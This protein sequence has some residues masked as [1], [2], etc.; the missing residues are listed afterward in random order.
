MSFHIRL[1]YIIYHTVSIFNSIIVGTMPL[2][3]KGIVKKISQRYI[4]GENISDAIRV[5][6]QFEKMNVYATIDVLGEFKTKKEQV[7]IEKQ[8]TLDLIHSI[9]ENKLQSYL[10]IKLTSIGMDIDEEYCFENL[11][12]IVTTAQKTGIFVRLDME[13]S[14]YTTKTINMYKKIREQGFSNIGIVIQAYLKRSENDIQSLLEYKPS[15]RLCKGIYVESSDIALKDPEQIR[16]NYKKLYHLLIENGAY[17]CIAT[18]DVELLN[19][20]LQDIQ[21]KGYKKH[22][23]EFQMLLGVKEEERTKIVQKGHTMRVYIPFGKDWYGYSTRRLKENPQI[24]LYVT[25]A[26]FRLD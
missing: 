17:T 21:N 1:T 25:K 14:P 24:A 19:Y 3:P 4:A 5:A 13:N 6:K 2:I 22:Q 18:H 16:E 11:L 8:I 9:N 23:F 15:I 7:E 26:L 12:E 20:C 10:S